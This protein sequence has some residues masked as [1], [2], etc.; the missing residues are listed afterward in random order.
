[1]KGDYRYEEDIT[2]GDAASAIAVARNIM[3]ALCQE[4]PANFPLSE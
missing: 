4:D 2:S 1:M 3:R